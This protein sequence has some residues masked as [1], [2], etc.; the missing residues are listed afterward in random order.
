MSLEISIPISDAK[1]RW[2]LETEWNQ[3]IKNIANTPIK[4]PNAR[5][6]QLGTVGKILKDYLQRENKVRVKALENPNVLA[7]L[8]KFIQIGKIRAKEL[9][10]R[11]EDI[12]L[13]DDSG[14]TG[15][16]KLLIK[17]V[18]KPGATRSLNGHS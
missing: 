18:A 12:Q 1:K 13:S 4:D 6:D 11:Y 5:Y 15:D 10:Y 14:I 7:F 2:I 16:G 9:G 3:H 17:F 8:K